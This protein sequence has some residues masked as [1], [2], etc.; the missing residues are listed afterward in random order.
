MKLILEKKKIAFSELASF[1]DSLLRV[2]EEPYL[3]L[4]E[5][6]LGA[7][8]TTFVRAW[9]QALIDKESDIKVPENLVS[10]PTFTLHQEYRIKEKKI[11]HF[12]LY[13]LRSEEELETT[14]FWEIFQQPESV[15]IEW[16]ERANWDGLLT[17][18]KI[19]RLK[20]QIIDDSARSIK[21]YQ[22]N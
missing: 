14:G 11:H 6:D 17:L 20:F 4:L 18:K 16:P 3:F 13:R 12:D 2:V 10:S 9:V 8:K 5:G 22:I 7:G 19:Y 15:I 21:V 1:C